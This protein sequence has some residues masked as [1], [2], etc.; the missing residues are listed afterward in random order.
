MRSLF[1][2]RTEAALLL[3]EKLQSL[4]G[5]EQEDKSKAKTQMSKEVPSLFKTLMDEQAALTKKR[6]GGTNNQTIHRLC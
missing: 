3:A 4:K 1:K 5:E 2:N 6:A